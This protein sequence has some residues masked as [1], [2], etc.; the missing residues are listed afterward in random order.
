LSATVYTI[1]EQ[2]G[3]H[4]SMLTMNLLHFDQF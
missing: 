3:C 4:R 1:G 2:R